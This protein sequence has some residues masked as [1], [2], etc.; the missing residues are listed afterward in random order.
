[1]AAATS[2]F[3]L[4]S[5]YTSGYRGIVNGAGSPGKY[6]VNHFLHGGITTS[7]IIPVSSD[8]GIGLTRRLLGPVSSPR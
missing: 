6:R 4:G 8:T 7:V 2:L 1:M 3:P 5:V